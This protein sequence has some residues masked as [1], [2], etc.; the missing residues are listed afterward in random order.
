MERY[1]HFLYR[2]DRAS[3]PVDAISISTTARSKT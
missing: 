1:V 3:A 2:I